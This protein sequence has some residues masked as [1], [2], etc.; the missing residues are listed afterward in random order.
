MK[1][2]FVSKNKSPKKK[3]KNEIEYYDANNNN[4]NYP[5]NMNMDR[6]TIIRM[7][8]SLFIV[9]KKMRAELFFFF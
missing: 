4:N 5:H 9:F 8:L 7:G 6:T 2:A 1:Y 3:N